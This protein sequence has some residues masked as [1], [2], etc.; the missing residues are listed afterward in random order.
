MNRDSLAALGRAVVTVLAGAAILGA[1]GALGSWLLVEVI[2]A[3]GVVTAAWWLYVWP[4]R[5]TCGMP[6]AR[7]P[8]RRAR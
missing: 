1:I 4:P 5:L 7:A 2:A 3:I 6:Q 8:R